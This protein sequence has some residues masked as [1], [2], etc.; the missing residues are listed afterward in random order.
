MKATSRLHHTTVHAHIED[1]WTCW[2]QLGVIPQQ[3]C[4]F[5][6]PG[7]FRDTIYRSTSLFI[8][9]Q[10]DLYSRR[11]VRYRRLDIRRHWLIGHDEICS[12]I[13]SCNNGRPRLITWDTLGTAHQNE[14][15][16]ER[17]RIS[18]CWDPGFRSDGNSFW[19]GI[20]S[21]EILFLKWI[22]L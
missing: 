8:I 15:P 11:Q 10:N 18:F 9:D 21:N 5:P 6:L 2:H 3:L 4:C 17:K 14:I 20:R 22:Y 13:S 12:S 19:P 1:L 16:S 7:S